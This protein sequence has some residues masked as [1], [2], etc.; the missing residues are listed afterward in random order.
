M[1]CG[2]VLPGKQRS[3]FDFTHVGPSLYRGVLAATC[4]FAELVPCRI[5]GVKPRPVG[6]RPTIVLVLDTFCPRYCCPLCASA[7]VECNPL[8]PCYPTASNLMGSETYC[9]A[10]APHSRL[11]SLPGPFDPGNNVLVGTISLN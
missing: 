5:L 4:V 11:A 1:G 8:H 7:D 9:P 3:V 6:V 10:K 2:P